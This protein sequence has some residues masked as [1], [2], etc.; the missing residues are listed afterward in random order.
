MACVIC[1]SGVPRQYRVCP[2]CGQARLDRSV[3]IEVTYRHIAVGVYYH[4]GTSMRRISGTR[5]TSWASVFGVLARL[6]SQGYS[7]SVDIRANIDCPECG[8]EMEADAACE[9]EVPHFKPFMIRD[10]SLPRRRE[11]HPALLCTG[12][13]HCEVIL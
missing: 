13:E 1:A 12:C 6:T 5:F 9:M 3:V 10:R 2:A 7:Y 8:S 4:P 11:V